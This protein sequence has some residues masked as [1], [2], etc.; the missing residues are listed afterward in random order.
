MQ[1]I[2][3]WSPDQEN[4]LEESM[5]T[6]SMDREGAWQATVHVVAKSQTWVSD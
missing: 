1:E 5:A 4:P 3:V 6:R 2:W